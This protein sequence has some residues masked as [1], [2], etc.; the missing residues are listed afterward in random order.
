MC[1]YNVQ[2]LGV[3]D[4]WREESR[5]LEPRTLHIPTHAYCLVPASL[6]PMDTAVS[7]DVLELG[8]VGGNH[9]SLTLAF[10]L[11]PPPTSSVPFQKTLGLFEPWFS[12]WVRTLSS[13]CLS[14]RLVIESRVSAPVG[15]PSH[16]GQKILHL[17]IPV[18]WRPAQV[19]GHHHSPEGSC[20]L[21]SCPHSVLATR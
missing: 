13:P 3:G 5:G 2:D 11:T 20:P 10:T 1:R 9:L 6:S 14:H 7:S 18:A 4:K 16:S 15:G 21:S 8:I 19:R 17:W 12:V